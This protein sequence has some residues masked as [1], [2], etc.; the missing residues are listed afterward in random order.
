MW[1][2]NTLQERTPKLGPDSTSMKGSPFAM[3]D[4]GGVGAGAF[5]ASPVDMRTTSTLGALLAGL[6]GG[7]VRST[8]PL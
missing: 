2:R 3:D 4:I 8:H 1:S 5:L 7:D 6:L